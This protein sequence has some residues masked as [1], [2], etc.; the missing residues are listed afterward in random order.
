MKGDFKNVLWLLLFV[1][2][3]SVVYSIEHRGDIPIPRASDNGAG[4]QD[5]ASPTTEDTS[6]QSSPA[7]VPIDK[8]SLNSSL[9]EEATA[10]FGR[11]QEAQA[12]HNDEIERNQ[13]KRLDIALKQGDGAAEQESDRQSMEDASREISQRRETE[14]AGARM[15]TACHLSN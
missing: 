5:V 3:I 4:H 15:R 12:T 13:E 10:E 2:V 7:P 6:S 1:A 11:I 14:V 8:K 9:C